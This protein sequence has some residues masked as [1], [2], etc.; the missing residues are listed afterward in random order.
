MI[1]GVAGQIALATHRLREQYQCGG[2]PHTSTVGRSATGEPWSRGAWLGLFFFAFISTFRPRGAEIS[3]APESCDRHPRCM[4]TRR[5]LRDGCDSPRR[6]FASPF[7]V[8]LL[9]KSPSLADTL[10]LHQHR[11]RKREHNEIP[12]GENPRQY[13]SRPPSGCY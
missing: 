3:M 5:S 1:R 7:Q 10:R 9:E 4:R 8:S 6:R 13:R 11:L 12:L 2:R